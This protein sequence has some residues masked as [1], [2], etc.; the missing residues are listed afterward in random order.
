[1][2][3]YHTLALKELLAQRVTSVLIL[4]AI[5]LSTM[6]T[7]VIGQS[8]GILSAMRQQQAIAI[9]GNRHAGFVQMNEEQLTALENDPRL[10]FVGSFIVV[11]NVR[12]DNTL[13]L[14]LSEFHEDVRTVY[15]SIS[16]IKEGRLPVAPMEIALPEDV[17][18]YLGFSGGLGDTISLSLSKALRHG[19]MTQSYDFTAE[20]TLVGI[21]ESNY[22]NYTAGVVNG[23]AGPGTAEML[24][25]KAYFYYNVDVRVADKRVFQ[26]TIDDLVTALNVHELDTTYNVPYLEALGIRYSAEAAD[27][28]DASGQGFSLMLAA[29]ILLGA[30]LLL[31]AGLVI[32]NILKIAVTRRTAQYG[33]L[34]AIGADKSQLYFLVS[35]QVLLLCAVGIPL[36]LVLGTLSAKG[37]LTAATGLLTPEIFLARDAGELNRLIAENSRGKGLFLLVS[38]AITLIF[39]LTA[40]LPAA[41]YAA[42]VAPTVAM[43]GSKVKIKRRSRKEKKIHNFEAFYARLNLKR[44]RGRTAITVLSLVMSIT[45][46][47]ALQ[48]AVGLLD[49]A[50]SGVAEHYGDYSITNESA[51]F[52][53]KEYQ[54][55]RDNT[56]VAELTAMQFSLYNQGADGY[57]V[58]IGFG[59]PLQ[60]GETFQVVGLNE[61]YWDKAFSALPSEIFKK[62][63]AGEGCMVRNPLP[64]VF[65]GQE[66]PRTSIQTGDVITVAGQELEVLATLNGYDTYLSVG[67]NGFV[68]GVQVV[69]N[70]DLYAA[71]TGKTT[72]N[73]LLP[74][75]AEG[76]DREGF[77]GTV[78]ALAGRIPGTLW[79]SYE[80]TDRQLAESFQQIQFLAWGLI[81]FVGLIGLLNIINTVYTNIHT[82][83]AEIGMQ[84]AIGMSAGSLFK[85]FL[86]EGAYYGLFAA[87]IG[88]VAGYICTIFVE[89]ATTDTIQLVAVPVIPI[90]EATVLAIGACLAATCIPLRRISKMNIVE[91]IEV[92]E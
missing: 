90:A 69:V 15:P 19:I 32:Y 70:E 57:P 31:A 72:Y 83:I 55:L 22:L 47:I 73:W 75:L 24:L 80:D 66:I 89:A 62:L 60:P 30:L 71:L 49:A 4:L 13:I 86:W 54:E 21:T 23:I 52:S 59:F 3:Q 87:V 7:A 91:S 85:V 11:G 50:G 45:V 12:M 6:M 65:E 42:R 41:R 88:S 16:A 20:F 67:N 84:R 51:G 74:A 38:A 29:G 26:A 44:S 1:M 39:A 36:G 34:R 14:G 33:V 27:V 46:F 68:N 76:V 92:V 56:Q 40:A 63:K 8:I 53:P 35:A 77:D 37:I 79:L 48:G 81:L 61:A 9:G 28:A 58:G 64:L 25:P 78:E 18:G 2:K 82:R 10:S 43:A 17:L 5:L